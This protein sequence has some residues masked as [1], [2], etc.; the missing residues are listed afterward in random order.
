MTFTVIEDKD[1]K[2]TLTN[3]HSAS[4]YGIPVLVI[5]AGHV[6]G[7]FGPADT[8][9][10]TAITAAYIVAGWGRNPARTQDERQAAAA[11]LRQWPEGPQVLEAAA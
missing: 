1:A 9:G 10:D 11:F 2:A 7:V 4:S 6:S 3:E 8:I 5:D